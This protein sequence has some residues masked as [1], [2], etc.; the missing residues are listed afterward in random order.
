MRHSSPGCCDREGEEGLV[1]GNCG[2]RERTKKWVVRCVA[3]KGPDDLSLSPELTWWKERTTPRGILWPPHAHIYTQ[4]PFL[5]DRKKKKRRE[6]ELPGEMDGA[7][8][9]SVSRKTVFGYG[10]ESG[11]EVGWFWM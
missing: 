11:Y 8:G 2:G 6:R 9:S 1:W 5:N 7:K 4:M 10:V 3:G